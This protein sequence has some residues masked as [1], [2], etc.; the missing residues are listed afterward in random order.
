MGVANILCLLNRWQPGVKLPF[1]IR[2]RKLNWAV[3][4]NGLAIISKSKL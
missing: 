4:F 3:G 2:K 1:G